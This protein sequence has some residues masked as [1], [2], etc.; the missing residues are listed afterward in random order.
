MV[1][2]AL[3]FNYGALCKV[4]LQIDYF[5]IEVPL[6]RKKAVPVQERSSMPEQNSPWL[7]FV[8]ELF[9]ETASLNAAGN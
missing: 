6:T 5:L 8:L 2:G 1:C 9:N 3:R 4:S 7:W